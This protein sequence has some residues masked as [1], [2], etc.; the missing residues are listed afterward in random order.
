MSYRVVYISRCMSYRVVYI[1]GSCDAL[2]ACNEIWLE[3]MVVIFP[4]NDGQRE[5]WK[6]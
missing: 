1:S 2:T 6:T 4:T 5:S 3:R